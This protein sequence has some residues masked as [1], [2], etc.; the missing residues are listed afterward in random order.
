MRINLIL[1]TLISVLILTYSCR[2]EVSNEDGLKGDG[3]ITD[4]LPADYAFANGF[5]PGVTLGISI[6][7][8]PVYQPDTSSIPP[9]SV[10]LDAPTSGNQGTQGSCTAWA[11]VY[12]LGSYYVHTNTGKAY[13]DTGNLSPKYTFN[14]ITKGNCTCTSLI[15]NLYILQQQG[16]ASLG[17]MPYDPSECLLQPTDLQMQN[18]ASARIKG[19]SS[20]DMQNLTLIKHALV[21]KKSVVF[22]I[23]VDHGFEQLKSPFIWKAHTDSTGQS[24]ALLIIGYDDSKNSLRILN[25][26]STRWADNGEAWIDYDFFLKYVIRN[27]YVL[28]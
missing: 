13:S 18:A 5:C 4:S 20:V 23:A 27:G 9:L 17:V 14:Q 28:N 26:W 21:N 22:A 25:S 16:A 11:V 1:A 19:F 3:I 10:R 8:I 6:D 15:D 12:G 2:K 7:S 24:H